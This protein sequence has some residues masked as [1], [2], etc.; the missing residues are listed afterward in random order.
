M[1]NHSHYLA[2]RNN[3]FGRLDPSAVR[4]GFIASQ[5]AIPEGKPE[6]EIIPI[7]QKRRPTIER[8]NPQVHTVGRA[9]R[10]IDKDG[11]Q[12][13]VD[14]EGKV[15]TDMVLLAKLRKLRMEVARQNHLPTYCIFHNNVLAML[16]TD[17][18]TTREEFLSIRGVGE[19]S[20][21]R[22]GDLF[23][24]AIGEYIKLR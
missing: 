12:V 3:D 23:I 5:Y 24:Q 10:T 4:P 6:P 2:W 17:K 18:P 9:D 7:K 8:R 22:F 19:R 14:S 15:L 1:L 16:A 20:Y 11:F 13:L 21:N